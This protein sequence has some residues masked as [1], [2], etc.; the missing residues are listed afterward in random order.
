MTRIKSTKPKSTKTKTTAVGVGQS[1]M[2]RTEVERHLDHI[3]Y[4]IQD[5][6]RFG[7][8]ATLAGSYRR[9]LKVSNDIDL[10]ITAPIPQFVQGLGQYVKKTLSA[11][12]V[13]WSGI[14]RLPRSRTGRRLDIIR[15]QKPGK[16]SSYWFALLYF[17]GSKDHNIKMRRVA[18]LRGLRLNQY[19]LF[20]DG[21][22][23]SKNIA[24][25]RDIFSALH[26]T[27]KAPHD[28]NLSF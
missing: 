8:G 25:E 4:L 18:Q 22:R 11:G 17:T 5:P 7:R 2:T 24:S 28:R 16:G 26:I 27:Y 1:P 13:K 3:K 12:P 9:G 6:R 21:K 14:V 19:G 10:I 15:T 20:K 23:V